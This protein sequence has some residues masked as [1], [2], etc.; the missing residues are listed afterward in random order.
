MTMTRPAIIR[1]TVAVPL[2]LAV[3][4]SV[5]A[6]RSAAGKTIARAGSTSSLGA[7]A[8]LHRMSNGKIA[9]FTGQH[10][11]HLD[12]INPDGSGQKHLT[13]LCPGPMH[14]GCL[15]EGYAWSPHGTRLAFLQ[16]HPRPTGHTTMSLFVV[17]ADGSGEKRLVRCGQPV[18]C[19]WDYGSGI[20]WSPNGSRIVFSDRSS[21][22]VVKVNG[23]GLRRLTHCSVTL[24]HSASGAITG[25][26]KKSC[27][28][29]SPTWSPDGSRIAFARV[30]NTGE[31]LHVVN[32]DGSGLKA[33]ARLLG[34]VGYPVW[35]PDGRSIAFEAGEGIYTVH[36]DGSHVMP[37]VPFS[38]PPGGGPGQ[39]S[40]SP[41]GTRILYDST[42]GYSTHSGGHYRFEVWVMNA[43]GTG[44]RRL[45]HSACCTSFSGFPTWSPDG[46]YI[47]FDLDVNPHP[48]VRP[49]GMYLMDADGRHLHR[50]T[51]VPTLIAWQPIP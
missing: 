26:D 29:V 10:D 25:R 20:S 24:T 47:A 6:Q 9:F 16:G 34:S 45:Y 36:A 48:Q 40:W 30:G 51:Q 37:L 27:T 33:L 42:P 15:I 13:A 12:V 14:P 49:S 23:G 43:N 11:P 46:K 4:F 17:N 22:Y 44:R 3:L 32:A 21:L 50:L 18:A 5:P 39:P 8:P 2:A 41:D 1:F 28:D 35:S 38:G 31:S 7:D 19:N